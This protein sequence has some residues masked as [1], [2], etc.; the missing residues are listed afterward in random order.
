MKK[1]YMILAI[2]A[3]LIV[4]FVVFVQIAGSKKFDA[5]YPDIVA[6]TDQ[7]IIA[8]GEYLVFGPAHCATCHVPMDKIKDVENGLKIPL[9]GG[10]EADIP[11]V[12]YIAGS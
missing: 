3:G 9:T 11:P 10:W 2:L 7:D 5:P 12:N 6:S 1:F 8:R 4:L